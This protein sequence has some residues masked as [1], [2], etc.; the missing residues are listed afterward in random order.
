MIARGSVDFA[1]IGHAISWAAA[2]AVMRAL[3]GPGPTPLSDS[4]VREILPWI[5]PRTVCRV[6]VRS[7][8]GTEV[9]G[10]YIDSFIPPDQLEPRY[11]RANLQRVRDAADCAIRKGAPIATLG[12]FSSIVLEGRVEL[13]PQDCGTV[14]TTGNTLTVAYI[15]RGL[16]QAAL[17]SGRSLAD[18]TLLIVGATGDVASGCARYLAS[19]VKGLLL[20]ARN[21]HRLRTAC[22]S[23]RRVN[24]EARADTE[25]AELLPHADLILCAASLKSPSLD[26]SCARPGAIIC[27]AGYPPNVLAGNPDGMTFSGGMGQMLGGSRLE[28][29]VT[30]GLTPHP[31]P[32]VAH[33]CVLEGVLLALE[34]RYEAFSRGRGHIT[35]EKVD[36][37]WGLAQKHGFVLAPFFHGES[38][39]GEHRAGLREA[40]A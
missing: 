23:L 15:V 31:F 40:L 28:P 22:E 38:P 27:D 8:L 17:L 30:R 20:C 13:L 34:K 6:H 36:E 24:P 9:C 1:L 16:E 35:P 21:P 2:A 11:Y 12:G 39:A 33:G 29:D 37:I 14:F 26:L 5:P 25:I 3:R 32:N 10:V 19:R 4:D 7:R 18:L